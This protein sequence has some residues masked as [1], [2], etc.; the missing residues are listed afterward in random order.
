MQSSV[1]SLLKRVEHHLSCAFP[2]AKLSP[3]PVKEPVTGMHR[4]P[5][6]AR[7]LH[8]DICAQWLAFEAVILT[9]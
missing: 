4:E 2:V 3:K 8:L 7:A 1:F 9:F 6:A 5:H